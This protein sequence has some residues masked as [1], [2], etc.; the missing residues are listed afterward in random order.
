MDFVAAAV[1]V[2]VL[3]SMHCCCWLLVLGELKFEVELEVFGKGDV[4]GEVG[5]A[6]A[7]FIVVAASWL[8]KSFICRNAASCCPSDVRSIRV[9]RES[10]QANW[11]YSIT[12]VIRVFRITRIM[13]VI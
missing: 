7:S 12:S 2:S 10:Y 5:D 11:D 4:E 13:R 8:L 6:F 1:V 9:I 3:A